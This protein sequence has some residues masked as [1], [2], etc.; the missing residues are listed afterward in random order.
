V[1]PA[2]AEQRHPGINGDLNLTLESR[3]LDTAG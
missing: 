2:G 3:P 1:L